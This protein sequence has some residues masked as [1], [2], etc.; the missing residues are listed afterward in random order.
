VNKLI[1]L[2]QELIRNKCV[3]RGTSD[4]GGEI[5]SA[6]TLKAFFDSYRIK[7]ELFE[8]RPGRACI[9]ARITG[10]NPH[11]P[12]LMY[13]G[14]LDVVPVSEEGWASNPFSGDE[15]GGYIWGRG[16]LDMLG[17]TAAAARAFVE[18]STSD[19]KPDGD[20]MFLAVADEEASGRLGARWL[21][22]NHWDKVK[23]DYMIVEGGGYFLS[24]KPSRTIAITRGE[25]GIGW[26]KLSARG[27]AGHGSL[28]YLSD[29]AAITIAQAVLALSRYSK[30]IKLSREYHDIVKNLSIG[31]FNRLFLRSPLTIDRTLARLARK[32]PGLAKHLHAL[33]R[34]TMCPNVVNAGYKINTI[35]D[36][37]SIECD[38]RLLPG[39]SIEDVTQAISRALGKLRERFE[40]E[41][42]DYFPSNISGLDTPLYEAVSEIATSVY[43]DA[44]CVPNMFSGVTDARFWRMRG[45][46]VYG[47]ALFDESMTL[48]E[49]TR[50]LHGKDERISVKSLELT[51]HFFRKLPDV[52]FAKAARKEGRVEIIS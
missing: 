23:V 10:T 11:A 26:T 39:E 17:M 32:S 31:F 40:V 46:V 41:I 5:K 22:E 6:L 8:S 44:T 50:A 42:I 30:R 45:T 52:L 12:S 36:L 19:K 35:P 25:K 18:L 9:L 3:N 20:I 21:V 37:G 29:N 27:S 15:R 16:T 48:D 49:Y 4:S 13:M 2:L 33:S 14:H 28:P 38:I 51:Y 7:S 34:M 1:P 47:F 24:T 43:P